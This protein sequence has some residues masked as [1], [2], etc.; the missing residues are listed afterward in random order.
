[1]SAD[2]EPLEGTVYRVQF[3]DG[4]AAEHRSPRH[5]SHAVIVRGLSSSV[6]FVR[7]WTSV[8]AAA[9]QRAASYFV[10]GVVVAL[11][12]VQVVGTYRR[13]PRARS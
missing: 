1:M 9:M 13:R 7:E 12:P 2:V 10:L 3:P 5:R 11:V 6:W 4:T 8:P